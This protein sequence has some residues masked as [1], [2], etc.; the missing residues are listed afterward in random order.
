MSSSLIGVLQH[1]CADTDSAYPEP[2]PS[3]LACLADVLGRLP[4]PRRTRGRRYPLGSL[5]ALCLVAVLGGATSLAAIARFAADTDSE[6]REQLG[7]T[8]STPN[9]STLGRLLARLDGD[10]LDDAVGAWL[11]RYVDDPVVGPGDTLV[12]LAVDG[13]TRRGSRT[14]GQAVHL[15]AAALHACQTVI[16]QRQV[17][18]KSNEIP[19]LAPLLDR[20]DLRGVVVTADA[21]HTQRAHAEHVIAASGHYLLVVKGNQKKLRKQLRGLPWHQIPLQARTTGAR[22]GRR[23]VRR[24]KVCTVRPGLFFPHAVQA[25]EIKRRRTHRKMQRGLGSI[26]RCSG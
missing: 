21:M 9:A 26:R 8:S 1:H 12:G 24:L 10:A 4:D 25:M 5:L 18:A 11:A 23:E 15:L 3:Q 13:K 19:A 16:A 22:H 6:L 20:I 2:E 14:D 7:L 17:A